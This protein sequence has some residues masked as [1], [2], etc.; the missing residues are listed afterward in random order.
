M[1]IRPIDKKLQYQIQKL[2]R[3]PGSGVENLG[4]N[5]KEADPTQKTEDPLM[6]RPNPSMLDSKI[7]MNA[8]VSQRHCRSSMAY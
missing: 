6:F 2:T 7:N 5:V 1:Q 8:E 4:L 3:I